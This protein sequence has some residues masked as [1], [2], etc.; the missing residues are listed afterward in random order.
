MNYNPALGPYRISASRSG[1]KLIAEMRTPEEIDEVIN[2]L[3]A[4]RATLQL[5][6][7][8]DPVSSEAM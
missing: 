6:R 8:S 7:R 5:A 2:V 1:V 4:V 3:G